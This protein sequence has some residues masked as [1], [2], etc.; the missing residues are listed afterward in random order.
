MN[1]PEPR[2]APSAKTT[3]MR[4]VPAIA[5]PERH[6]VNANSNART[7]DS[8]VLGS[9]LP[10]GSFLLR[11]LRPRANR[12]VGRWNSVAHATALAVIVLAT[13]AIAVP[14]R[15]QA[16]TEHEVPQDWTLKP[17]D[18]NAGDKFRLLFI[19][20][21][22]RDA[23][24]TG[25]ADYNTFVQNRA[26][27][28]VAP[29]Q[30]YSS[31][32]RALV[33]T[34]AVNAR[35]NT[36][37]RATD[38][39]VPIY[40][41]RTTSAGVRVAD[42]VA[43]DYADFY[44]GTWKTQNA[45]TESGTL[46]T[47]GFHVAWTGTNTDG[48]THAT[49]YMGKTGVAENTA[50][51]SFSGNDISVRDLDAASM[52]NILA[53]SP[54]F[55]VGTPPPCNPPNLEG[56]RKVWSALLTVEEVTRTG[57][58]VVRYGVNESVGDLSDRDFTIGSNHY[59]I[60]LIGQ[61]TIGTKALEIQLDR[62]LSEHERAN[63]K[64][65]VC[66]QEFALSDTV[67]A[68]GT[69][70]ATYSWLNSGLDWSTT[71]TRQLALST[72]G[73][74]ALEDLLRSGDCRDLTSRG[75]NCGIGSSIDQ[76]AGGYSDRGEIQSAGDRDLWSIILQ[77]AH[78]YVIEVKGSGDPG[79]DNGGTLSDPSVEIYEMDWSEGAGWS[80]TKR[81]SNDNVNATNK[82]A[83]VVYTYPPGDTRQT[84]IGIR[85]MG[86]N[87]ATGSY[88]VSVK[89]L[90]GVALTETTDCGSDATTACGIEVGGT[91]RGTL[92][93]TSDIDAWAVPLVEGKTYRID[94]RGVDSGGGTLPDPNVTLNVV[95]TGGAYSTT[96]TDSDDGTGVDARIE[97]LIRAGLGNTY[98][99]A[100]NAK[101]NTAGGT[102]TLTVTD[103]SPPLVPPGIPRSLMATPGD[104][105]VVLTWRAPANLGGGPLEGYDYR[106][107]A[108]TSV[109]SDTPWVS[110]GNLL[111]GGHATVT[112]LD[113]GTAYAFEVR[114]VNA[115][116]AGDAATATAALVSETT[117][118]A[119]NLGTT[120][121]INV[122]ESE[123]GEWDASDLGDLWGVTLTAERTYQFDVK[124]AGDEDGDNGG[125]LPDP[126]GILH[127]SNA[128]P[129]ASNNDISGTN[130]NSR[131]TYM[132]PAGMGGKYFFAVQRTGTVAGTYTITVTD[133]TPMSQGEDST[134]LTVEFA[135]TPYEHDGT[136]AF[137][138]DVRFSDAIATS[139]EQM[140]ARVEITGGSA[141]GAERLSVANQEIWRITVTPSGEGDIIVRVPV[142]N[143]CSGTGAICAS[144]GRGVSEALSTT[145]F[146]AGLLGHFV[147]MP[148]EHDGSSTFTFE[149]HFSE[150]PKVS[151]RTVRDHLFTIGGGNVTRARRVTK[152]SNLAFEVT[153]EPDGVDDVTLLAG[154]TSDC[155]ARAS[156]CT[157]DGRPMQN[158]LSATVPGPAALSVA[159]TS[160]REAPG[161]TLDFVVS[162]NRVRHVATTVDYATS[163]GTA[164][165]PDDYTHTAGTLTFD[166]G[167]REK[168]VSV[169]V[170]DDGHDDD[171][172]TVILTLSKASAPTRITDDTAIGT[173]ENS[174]PMPKAWLVRF[175]RTVGSQVVDALS[176]RFASSGRSHVTVG[177][178]ELRSGTMAQDGTND[179]QESLTL[180]GWEDEAEGV[181]PE[182]TMTLDELVT[183]TRFHLSSGAPDGGGT[184]FTAWGRVATNGF[185]AEVDD[186]TMDGDVTS[187][188]VG[189][190][191]E[192][193]RALAGVMLSQS[194]GEGSY[195]LNPALGDDAGTVKSNL[196]GVYPYARLTLNPRLSAWA[197][198]GMGS[199]ELTLRQNEK[200]DMPTDIEMRM[201][202]LG[203]NA[204]VLDAADTGGLALSVK[205]DAMWVSTKSDATEELRS[206]EGDVTRLRLTLHGERAFPLSEER[207]LTPSAEIGLRHDAG[208][209]ET[210]AGLEVG[211]GLR[212]SA[213]A[214]TMEGRVRTL[215][216]HA[217]SG[218]EEWGASG[219]IQVVPDSSGRGLTLRI[220]P[221]WGATRSATERL[222]GAR[223]AGELG[224]GESEFEAQARVESEIG[225]GFALTRNRGLVTP[226]TALSLGEGA[227][228]T[229]RLGARWRASDDVRVG[230]E[231][232]QEDNAS[233]APTN[234]V[235]LR[236]QLRW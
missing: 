44:D 120:C 109:P 147:D 182:R 164:S 121:T 137:N 60:R 183:G 131:F 63:L 84:P 15:V 151:Y 14:E 227:S 54:V 123:V 89:G 108:G 192:W 170:V 220:A 191:A 32:F 200:K 207:T 194:S 87:G 229:W 81:A 215:I 190:D 97:Y 193:D 31:N 2:C 129:V 70:V 43:D 79:G 10:G 208:D 59:N 64:L 105:E 165:A 118:C 110:V 140:R 91:V 180:A 172:E 231:G 98:Y 101:A 210:G 77:R 95:V 212:Y 13:L 145:V 57:G 162:L 154:P 184:A 103:M 75:P 136:T 206:T 19:T 236:A 128:A 160:V 96:G 178:I 38:T 155:A 169:P 92:S 234:T 199:G 198:A 55:K 52:Q 27:M 53:L 197:L 34:Q 221:A 214:L 93:S 33:S 106:H 29:I 233:D 5:A 1:H 23:T 187:A 94:V 4:A 202:A 159:D 179:V 80:G 132:V 25:I 168:T 224:S 119:E 125:T 216:A 74:P 86:A 173:I 196:T 71:A 228:R 42:R 51:W 138:V 235:Q 62:A 225:Y 222:W 3:T 174:D 201:G 124:G 85:V 186:V 146:R 61:W 117:D 152:R 48:T 39:D 104:G 149:V 166:A 142:T 213:G 122:G 112:G 171:G 209:A 73:E 56:H 113:N 156:V 211:A 36:Q 223:D 30:A 163:D 114:A 66:A 7:R 189:F 230:L 11:L 111:T 69:G 148:R 226:Y 35:V 49:N 45:R 126:R 144:G 26:A 218:Y 158:G 195:R 185:E 21:T 12:S 58:S 40:W 135:A 157:R 205:S 175:G 76:R 88:T 8:A 141:T 99:I 90:Q 50:A 100:V 203:V 41:V 204:A 177:G 37:T 167:E 219:S 134:P 68:A 115:A 153:V 67:T 6:G 16:Q 161:A 102:Y 143:D 83:R 20:S 133:I 116:G 46:F 232:T 47:F 188:L 65:H 130:K 78:S 22:A 82:N 181:G 28:G 217:D 176:D 107:A 150:A 9:S 24:S 72:V 17:A 127:D 18:I 139:A